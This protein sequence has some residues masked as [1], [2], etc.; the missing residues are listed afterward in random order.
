MHNKKTP[1]LCAGV[2]GRQSRA[3][4]SGGDQTPAA[5]SPLVGHGDVHSFDGCSDRMH[6]ACASLWVAQRE[7]EECHGWQGA[8]VLM[9][10]K[11]IE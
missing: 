1:F 5:D 8:P 10:M 11:I 3:D 7:I 4:G 9:W 2:E 6:E